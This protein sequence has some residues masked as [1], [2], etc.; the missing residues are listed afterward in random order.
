MT[1]IAYKSGV[2]AFDSRV[3]ANGFLHGTTQKG[4][5]TKK[6]IAAACGELQ[7]VQAFLDWIVKTD[8]DLTRK[9][10][11]GLHVPE[12]GIGALVI[13]RDKP[14]Q[15][16]CYDSAV[17]PYPLA[18]KFAALGSGGDVALG[19]MHMGASAY[20]AVKTASKVDMGTDDNVKTY[21]V[22]DP[23]PKKAV[24]PKGKKKK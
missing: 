12:I 2:L 13:H 8:G 15:I 5:S 10:E 18:A 19:A 23:A 9:Q 16:I 22:R 1:T 24:K 6:L 20:T 4:V 3:T 17:Y 11:F 7:Y 21:S 14:D